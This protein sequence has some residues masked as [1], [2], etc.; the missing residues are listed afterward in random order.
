MKRQINLLYG[1]FCT[2]V[3]TFFLASCS[4]KEKE[5]PI[6]T[7]SEEAKQ[8]FIQ[9]RE[10]FDNIELEKAAK[11]FEDAIKKDS[12]FALAY[13]YRAL[14]GGGS[15][16]LKN[17]L[18]KAISLS[19]KVTE[20]E[21]LLIKARKAFND[22]DQK[23]GREYLNKLITMFPA[24]MLRYFYSGRNFL[25]LGENDSAIVH[26]KKA[27]ELDAKYA[28]TYNFLGYAYMRSENYVEAEKEFKE[29]IRLEPE[30]PNPY[31]S[32]GEYL[33]KVGRFDESIENYA[34]SNEIDPS[35]TYAFLAIGD[36]YTFKGDYTKA[37]EYYQMYF[38]KAKSMDQKMISKFNTALSFIYENKI[39]DAVA[40]IKIVADSAAKQ[41]LA[42]R[43]TDAYS[44]IQYIYTELGDTKEGVA[45]GK[46]AIE[47]LE[48]SNLSEKE[49]ESKLYDL[50]AYLA[51]SHFYNNDTK[52]AMVELEKYKAMAMK[53]KDDKMYDYY[54]GLGLINLKE[55]KYEQ[56]IEN[57]KKGSPD[58]P[59]NLYC[60]VQ[61]YL[62]N[63]NKDEGNKIF[64]ELKNW[65]QN[66]LSYAI[67]RNKMTRE[68]I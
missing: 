64:N 40:I 5:M 18:E 49:K 7:S 57:F 51:F 66:D 44:S 9:G 15:E 50:T 41:N 56:A 4:T 48:K 8:L 21:Q 36:I 39:N 31:D 10:D 62:R 23:L 45:Y 34:K 22:N 46:K 47:A 14:S 53:K 68:K 27:I 38:D 2:V 35:F 43:L 28:A 26:L 67:V 17:N 11:L 37:R 1:L 30:R 3:V 12:I 55:K 29:Y 33:L 24:D 60:L 63:G 25:A 20:G 13:L 16:V 59:N 19:D 65:N 32:Y 42:S 61:A 54:H 58:E 52:K 6:T